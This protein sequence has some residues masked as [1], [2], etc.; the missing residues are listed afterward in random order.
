MFIIELGKS[1]IDSTVAIV[2]YPVDIF[3]DGP[4]QATIDM[5]TEIHHEIANV[6]TALATDPIGA[7]LTTVALDYNAK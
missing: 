2:T 3:V 4:K 1:V 6:G 5:V 7:I